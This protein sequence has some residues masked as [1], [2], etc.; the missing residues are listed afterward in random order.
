MPPAAQMGNNMMVGFWQRSS[1]AKSGVGSINTGV[2]EFQLPENPPQRIRSAT[3]Q[4]RGHA[5]QC[6]GAD[7]VVFEVF[8]YAG[9]GWPDPADALSGVRLGRLT[10]TCT[11]NPAFTQVID[12]SNTLIFLEEG[13]RS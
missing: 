3:L 9:N 13:Q 12:A 5:S 6:A 7:A 11:D 10:G 4:F 2:I 1:G 8:G